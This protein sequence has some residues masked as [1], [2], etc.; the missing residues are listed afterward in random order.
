MIRFLL[1]T[2]ICFGTI[3]SAQAQEENVIVKQFAWGVKGGLT[4]GFQQWNRG[5]RQTLPAYHGIM[6][7]ESASEE[8]KFAVFAQAGFHVKGSAVRLRN[9]F[10][11]G[12][13]SNQFTDRYEYY[14]ASLTLGGKQKF[15]LNENLK[16]YYLFGIRGDY[17]LG[18]NLDDYADRNSLFY[19]DNGFVREWNY[20][21]TIGGGFEF[22]FSEFISGL[23]EFT[24]NPDFSRQ[25]RQPPLTVPD[26]FNPGNSRMLSETEIINR[27][28]EVTLGIRFL[29]RVEYVY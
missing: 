17:T 27:T 2:L 25:Y 22:P 13:R 20:G 4:L 18:T 19:P 12:T 7:I 21:V 1:I 24:F 3:V 9:I 15:D 16:Y 14:N 8:D 23:L 26:P 29:R 6:F 5:D 28:F 11:N 10:L